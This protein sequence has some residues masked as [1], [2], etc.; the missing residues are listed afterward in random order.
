M[1]ELPEVETVCRSLENSLRGL[2]VTC[3]SI[4]NPHLRLRYPI[5]PDL[6]AQLR[7]ACFTQITRR[8]K[9][10]L[11]HFSTKKGVLIV[12]L[13]MSGKL[14]L[15]SKDVPP[16]KHEHVTIFLSND[17]TLRFIDPRRFGALLWGREDGN[18]HPVLSNLG[19]E[20]L[21]SG[22]SARYLYAA[23]QSHRNV[24]IKQL[25]MDSKVVV[26]VGNIYASE[27][28]FVGGILPQRKASSLCLKECARLVA[29][30]KHVLRASIKHGGTT[31]RDF[32][33]GDGKAGNFV[34]CLK[35]YGRAGAPC[36]QCGEKLIALRLGQRS[37]VYCQKCQN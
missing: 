1:P 27:A 10:I 2:T 33:S 15:L 29:A 16:F 24:A 4:N 9:Y 20:P 13:G 19:A 23:C 34:R 37:T 25:I 3:F 36:L 8:A 6:P 5:P 26:G 22:F 31:I 7:G 28:L 14:L 18:S 17:Q 35:V 11:L 21:S 32:V 30:I 12:H